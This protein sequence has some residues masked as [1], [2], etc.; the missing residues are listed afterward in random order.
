MKRKAEKQQGAAPVSAF[1]ARRARQQERADNAVVT[2]PRPVEA[3][4][5][6]E[7]PSK[8]A[9]RAVTKEEAAETAGEDVKLQ[10][11]RVSKKPATRASDRV[12]AKKGLQFADVKS[13]GVKSI[14]VTAA[15]DPVSSSDESSEEQDGTVEDSGSVEADALLGDTEGYESPSKPAEVQNF[16]LSK[17][18]LNKS[19]VV[20]SGPD[21]VCIRIK[22]KMNLA[23]L[24]QYDLWVKRG[25]VS[26]MGAKLH[27][28]PRVYRVYAPSTH[29][30]PII[31][32]VS[33]VDG[34]AEVE[35]KSCQSGLYRLKDLSTVYQ[36]IWNKDATVADNL[37]LKGHSGSFRR[38]FSILHT[39]ADDSLK[40]HLRPLHLEKKWSTSIKA[41]S[42]RG[43]DLKALVCGP[44]ASGKSTFSRYL[45]NHLLSPAPQTETGHSNTDGVAFLDLDPGQPEFAPMGQIYLA[46]LR[47]PFFGPPFTHPSLHNTQDGKILRSHYIGATS[48]KEDPDHYVL[49][50]MDL[51]EQYRSLLATHPQCP[52][53]INYPG[54][55]F[56][57]GLEVATWLIRSLGLSD[58]VYMSEKG[59][60]E[61]VE[62]LR[63]AARDASTSLTTLPSQPTDY[64]SRSSAQLRAMQIQSYFHQ[65]HPVKLQNPV[66]QATSMSRTRPVRVDYAGPRP[67]I[68]GVMVMGSR[69]DATLLHELV[70]GSIVG[71]VAVES[72]TALVG[73]EA[74][75]AHLDPDD[76]HMDDCDADNDEDSPCMTTNPPTLESHTIRA[77]PNSVPYIF[78]GSGSCNP[79]DPR[80]SR[81]LGLAYVRSIDRNRRQME[82]ITPI[83]P[84]TIRDA[85]EHGATGIV[86]VCGQLDSPSWA[87]SE[88]YHS[89]RAAEKRFQ[90]SLNSIKNKGRK[91]NSAAAAAAAAATA[92]VGGKPDPVAVT[93][94]RE[95]VRHASHGPWMTVVED[96]RTAGREQALWKLRKLAYVDSES[97]T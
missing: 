46:H 95:R 94:L 39:S 25:V 29:S 14:P 23:L 72:S 69:I 80:A 20:Y 79:L 47:S 22:E 17:A 82:L 15:A 64:V 27:P 70:E 52:L 51:M 65:S 1:A 24:G 30:L 88:E 49:A 76:V 83:P 73:E 78:S 6:R 92:R 28:S 8:K 26:I 41:L 12:I 97:E 74:Q 63:Q 10:I 31:K 91:G 62:P 42:Q 13:R 60:A 67:G 7:P 34:E 68:L 33:G 58:V 81:C 18:P 4:P 45:L 55:I 50:A 54:W 35:I 93:A 89:A 59:P 44:K 5:A 85:L 16:P 40:R 57:Q 84:S 38:S 48:P 61:V 71:V 36:R 53:I 3:E 21:T 32:C 37:T 87:V 96:T 9:R 75:E 56:G 43:G 2:P 90:R 77:S 11:S 86:L 66:W 19:S